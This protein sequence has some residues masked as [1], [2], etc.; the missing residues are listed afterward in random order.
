LPIFDV[1][2]NDLTYKHSPAIITQTWSSAI[3]LQFRRFFF[4]PTELQ[5][6]STTQSCNQGLT[7]WI[8]NDG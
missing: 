5:R 6:N 3:H 7:F 1:W 8:W 2:Q 4:Y